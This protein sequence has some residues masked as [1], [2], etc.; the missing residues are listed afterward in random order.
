MSQI[1]I[2]NPILDPKDLEDENQNL[3]NNQAFLVAYGLICLYLA[4][5]FYLY[6]QPEEDPYG[7]GMDFITDATGMFQGGGSVVNNGPIRA[8]FNNMKD[9][10]SEFTYE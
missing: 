1:E 3:D 8:G 2:D 6:L 10:L 9:A 5:R 7:L 4:Y